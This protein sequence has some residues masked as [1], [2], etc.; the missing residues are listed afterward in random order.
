MKKNFGVKNWMFPMPVLMIGTYNDDGSPDMMNAAWGGVSFD[1]QLT[2]CIDTHH[3]T[4]RNIEK[5]KAFT[6]AFGTV[7][8][9]K[10]CDYLGIVSGDKVPDKVAKC[11][12]TARRSA[13]VDAPVMEELPLVMEC[14]LISM[15]PDNC[16]V[17]GRIVNCA[18]EESALTDGKPDAA[19]MR[20]IC[21]DTCVHVYRVMGE[22]VAKAFSC[23]KELC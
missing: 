3:K 11:G 2:I 16:N 7:G 14:E 12:F 18:A 15:N 19:K 13:F 6:V 5:R 1:D 21:F 8:T 4:W 9:V 23:G 10:S 20:P 17:V 22:V